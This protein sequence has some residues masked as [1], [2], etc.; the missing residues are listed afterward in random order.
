MKV[1][2]QIVVDP[3]RLESV[4]KELSKLNEAIS[5]Y[6]VTG[7]FD[8]FVELNVNSV[9]EFRDIM[10][11]KILKINGVKLTESSIVLGE[12]K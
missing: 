4:C 12:W 7:E 2:V 8:I 9:K 11:N 3:P 6:E 1:L 10:K 5:V